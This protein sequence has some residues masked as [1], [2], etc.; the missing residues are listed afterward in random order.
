MEINL[1]SDLGENSIDFNGINDLK[2]LKI[3]NSANIA[4][5]YHAGD[6]RTIKRTIINSKMNNVSIGAH[7]GFKDFKNFGRKRINLTETELTYLIRDQLEI[8]N[9]IAV[10]ENWPLTHVKPHGALNNMACENY[11]IANIIGKNIKTFNKDLIYVILPLN[12]MEKAAQKLNIKFACEIFADRNY[13]DNGQL[14]SR[15]KNNAFIT[16]EKLAS[17]KI[18][19]MINESYVKC[20]SGKKIKCKIDTICIHGDNKNAIKFAK[21]I[22]NDLLKNGIRLSPIYKLKKFL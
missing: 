15:K 22:K 12:Q 21:K 1:N 10:N 16:D 11:E 8:I 18:L 2:I 3:I 14:F 17:N 7:P 19:E 13:E 20:Y 6:T 5:G 9:E 4:C